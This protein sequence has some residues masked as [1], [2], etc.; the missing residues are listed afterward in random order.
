M[1]GILLTELSDSDVLF[2]LETVNS[3]FVIKLVALVSF[4]S[5]KLLCLYN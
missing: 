2:L 3:R 1:A 5:E 4:F